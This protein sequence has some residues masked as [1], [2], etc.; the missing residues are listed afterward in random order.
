LEAKPSSKTLHSLKN[1]KMDK[2]K[3]KK[4]FHVVVYHCQSWNKPVG[5]I[6]C[7]NLL[8]W[9]KNY[10]LLMTNSPLWSYSVRTLQQWDHCWMWL[11]SYLDQNGHCLVATLFVIPSSGKDFRTKCLWN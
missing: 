8:N 7:R 11:C 1:Q 10:Q 6:K 2:V 4:L 9:Q 5:T 3:K